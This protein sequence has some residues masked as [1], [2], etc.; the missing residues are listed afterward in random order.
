MAELGVI[1]DGDGSKISLVP[2]VLSSLDLAGVG[3][4]SCFGIDP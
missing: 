3:T 2:L 1:T 4:G